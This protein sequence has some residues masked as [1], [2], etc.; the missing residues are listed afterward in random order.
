M[1]SSVY[2]CLALWL[3]FYLL[4][5]T[6]VGLLVAQIARLRP[7]NEIARRHPR[8]RWGVCALLGVIAA[9]ITLALLA[10]LWMM[11]Q[12][13]TLWLPVHR[14]VEFERWLRVMVPPILGEPCLSGD[15]ALCQQADQYRDDL[16][17]GVYLLLLALPALVAAL[18][19]RRTVWRLTEPYH[20]DPAHPWRPA[21]P[22]IR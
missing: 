21:D 15:A 7:L 18:I 2:T 11:F 19:T 3:A 10:D 14:T 4:L 5:V 13:D 17:T 12:R 8:V 22:V 1:S 6:T 16:S 9:L 20:Y